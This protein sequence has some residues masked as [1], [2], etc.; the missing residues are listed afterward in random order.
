MISSARITASDGRHQRLEEVREE[1]LAEGAD[2]QRGDR[3]AEL[4]RRDEPR[5]VGRDPQHR[6]RAAVALALELADPRAPRG[7]E[8]VLG[9]DEG[10]VQQDQAHEGQ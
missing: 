8:A 1:R 9:G 10:R 5:R 6:A 2:R 7:D 3:D 4:H